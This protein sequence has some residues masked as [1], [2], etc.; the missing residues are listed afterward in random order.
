MGVEEANLPV[1]TRIRFLEGDHCG[2]VGE[3]IAVD[4]PSQLPYC[5][6]AEG[7]GIH[8]MLR[9]AFEV[10][11]ESSLPDRRETL[12]KLR[13]MSPD[14][15]A[16]WISGLDD[17]TIDRLGGT[18]LEQ[19]FPDTPSDNGE[20]A[21]S[22][23]FLG[24]SEE[25]R[26]V[27]DITPYLRARNAEHENT[28]MTEWVQRWEPVIAAAKAWRKCPGRHEARVLMNAIDAIEETR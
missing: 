8:Y 25:A 22:D 17:E 15:L 5:A 21:I 27:R 2:E 3:L 24:S 16:R 9:E 13:G 11:P 1:G 7:G 18:G 19:Q 20:S 12:D 23:P 26:A 6:T 4:G 28:Q 14:Q 10:I